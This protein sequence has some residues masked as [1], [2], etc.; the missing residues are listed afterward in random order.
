MSNSNR[1]VRFPEAL[2][3]EIQAVAVREQRS[4]N[5]VVVRTLERALGSLD[6]GKVRMS[7][8][9]S[10]TVEGPGTVPGSSRASKPVPE[11]KPARAFA[12]SR[13]VPLSETW[14]R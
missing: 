10:A 13:G 14:R 9:D 3:V 8:V 12:E 2:R 11:V 5:W 6:A 7:P 1:S 4:F